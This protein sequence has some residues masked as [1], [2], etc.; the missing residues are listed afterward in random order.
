MAAEEKASAK[1]KALWILL[2]SLIIAVCT[3]GFVRIRQADE[4]SILT[5]SATLGPKGR[6]D[7]A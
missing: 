4:E 1:K 5:T 7:G 2:I 6:R 3:A